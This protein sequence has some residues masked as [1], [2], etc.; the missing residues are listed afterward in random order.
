MPA[1]QTKVGNGFDP[2]STQYNRHLLQPHETPI[3]PRSPDFFPD[4]RKF[5][6]DHPVLGNWVIIW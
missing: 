6:L 4:F 2:H 1:D 5:F 3:G